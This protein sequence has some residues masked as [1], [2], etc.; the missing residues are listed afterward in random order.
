M[1]CIRSIGFLVDGELLQPEIIYSS[2]L[3]DARRN[4]VLYKN[5][6]NRYKSIE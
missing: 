3:E 1:E 6:W 5:K 2:S 4:R